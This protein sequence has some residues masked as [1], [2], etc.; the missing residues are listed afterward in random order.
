M[1]RI[2]AKKDKIKTSIFGGYNKVS[3]VR[4]LDKL[5]KKYQ[6]IID[7][8]SNMYEAQIVEKDKEIAKLLKKK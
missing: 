5:E 4:N 8:E 6:E 7:E 2:K 1:V 3:V